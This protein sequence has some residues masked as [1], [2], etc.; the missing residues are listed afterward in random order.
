MPRKSSKQHFLDAITTL[1]IRVASEGR[2]HRASRDLHAALS[3]IEAEL[4]KPR[5]N[6]HLVAAL[7]GVKSYISNRAKDRDGGVNHFWTKIHG[8]DGPYSV[9]DTLHHD[10]SWKVNQMPSGGTEYIGTPRGLQ[11]RRGEVDTSASS[12]SPTLKL[13]A[14]EHA[15][16]VERGRREAEARKRTAQ[17]CGL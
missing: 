1:Q 14:E 7:T 17:V 6:W 11:V 10:A 4:L 5:T 12:S 3:E 8:Q 16:I 13:I 9:L 2:Y 15:F